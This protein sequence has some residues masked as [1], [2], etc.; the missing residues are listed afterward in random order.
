M[1]RRITRKQLKEDEFVSTMDHLIRRFGEYWKVA[2]GVIGALLVVVFAWWVFSQ[3]MGSRVEAASAKLSLVVT[4]YQEALA[5]GGTADLAAAE[6][7]ITE[8]QNSLNAVRGMKTNCT[9]ATKSIESVRGSIE[10]METTIR[11]KLSS[12]RLQLQL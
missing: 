10:E 4:T 9:Q 5:E 11:A 12:L 6:G 8:I 2:L 7:T 3:W 1:A